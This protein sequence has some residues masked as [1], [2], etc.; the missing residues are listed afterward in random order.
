MRLTAG[1]LSEITAELE[2][3]PSKIVDEL[4]LQAGH[5]GKVLKTDGTQVAW[6][7]GAGSGVDADTLDGQHASAFAAAS[8]THTGY[9]AAS[10]T[11]TSGINADTL[12]WVGPGYFAVAGHTHAYV[13]VDSWGLLGAFLLTTNRALSSNV[14]GN[15]YTSKTNSELPAGTW[16]LCGVVP[17]GTN[18]IVLYQRAA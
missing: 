9:A 14:R 10:H 13:P 11:H 1:I 15:Y 7:G 2:A 16:R 18:Y 4:P 5:A 12:G 3:L 6:A 8:H 17:D